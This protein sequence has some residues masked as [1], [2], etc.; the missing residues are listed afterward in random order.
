MKNNHK[1]LAAMTLLAAT[2]LAHAAPISIF[3]HTLKNPDGGSF[4]GVNTRGGDVQNIRTTYNETAQTFSWSYTVAPT[5]NGDVN[6]GFWLVVSDG[7]D[8]KNDEN[9]YAI[10]FGDLDNNRLTAYLYSGENNARSWDDPGELLG[11]FALTVEPGPQGSGTQTVSFTIDVDDI[12]NY[13]DDALW[14][15]ISF[16][17]SLGIWFHPTVGTR[18]EYNDDGEITRFSPQRYG[19]GYYDGNDI[20]VSQVPEP[21]ILYLSGLGLF[22]F[23]LSRKLT[24]RTRQHDSV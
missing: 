12:N 13:S 23:A 22:A 9:E 14:D 1:L 20:V 8:P 5:E 19:A 15:G 3:S 6:D 10:L 11:D 2:G 24:S 18:V 16:G 17:E 21:T 7:P 4:Q